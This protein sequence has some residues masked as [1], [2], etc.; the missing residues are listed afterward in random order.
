M[1]F[2]FTRPG[3]CRS[4]VSV[5]VSPVGVPLLVIES[6]AAALL[7]PNYG[8]HWPVD[9]AGQSTSRASAKSATG[10]DET[11]GLLAGN[12]VLGLQ[13]GKAGQAGMAG[14]GRRHGP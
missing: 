5:T 13:R 12:G 11:T 8:Y 7:I 2:Y 1:H 3:A 10:F 14:H 4:V 6:V 9:R